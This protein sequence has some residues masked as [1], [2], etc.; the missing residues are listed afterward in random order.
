MRGKGEHTHRLPDPSSSGAVAML[1]EGLVYY[2]GGK[3][4]RLSVIAQ[5]ADELARDVSACTM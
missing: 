1:D 5:A 2:V 4:F 3:L